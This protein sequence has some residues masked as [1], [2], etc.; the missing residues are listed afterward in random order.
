M[1]CETGITEVSVPCDDKAEGFSH[2]SAS[3]TCLIALPTPGGCL[4]L[5]ISHY[6]R[7]LHLRSRLAF[8]PLRFLRPRFDRAHRA[9]ADILRSSL[10]AHPVDLLQIFEKL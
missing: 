5:Q 4:T 1:V 3:V 8:R 10:S 2:P 7:H 6:R 9:N